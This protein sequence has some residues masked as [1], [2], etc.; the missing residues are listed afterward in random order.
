MLICWGCQSKCCQP[1]QGTPQMA[2]EP[3]GTSL[4]SCTQT[5][6]DPWTSSWTSSWTDTVVFLASSRKKQN[7]SPRNFP[8]WEV[9]WSV[10]TQLCFCCTWLRNPD[11]SQ[12]FH[13]FEIQKGFKAW[14]PPAPDRRDGQRG[15]SEGEWSIVNSCHLIVL[16]KFN[17]TLMKNI[18]CLPSVL[19]LLSCWSLWLRTPMKWTG[20]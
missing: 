6:R 11:V 12:F 5:R 15:S 10:Y 19:P 9:P 14:R 17:P 18:K 1:A 8:S 2:Q 3:K 16:A 7:K 4:A 20:T 13:F